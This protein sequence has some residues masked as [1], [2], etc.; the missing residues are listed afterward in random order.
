MNPK[1][2]T[3]ILFLTLSF[4]MVGQ[5]L[6]QGTFVL[7]TGFTYTEFNFKNKSKFD[8]KYS[9]CTGGQ[10]G[11]GTYTFKNGELLLT[12]DN[13]KGKPMPATRTISKDFSNNDTSY[14]SFTFYDPKDTSK[15]EGVRLEYRD[16]LNGN[17]YGT[18]SNEQG[19]AKLKFHNAQLPI[20]IKVT[21][22]GIDPETIIFDSSG[23]Y[24]IA[25]PLNFNFIKPF[26]KGQT[27]KFVIDDFDDEELVLKPINE[28]EFR[29]FR[30][31][32]E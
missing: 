19:K 1:I 8:Y 2:L 10:E 23:I 7:S 5:Q 12:F 6:P 11:S 22:I 27:L 30:R 29:T 32:Y 31:K 28:K 15:V 4:K 14:L 18:I 25:Y 20:D 17:S 26:V 24:T 9:S 13:P 21:Y 16:K 3:F